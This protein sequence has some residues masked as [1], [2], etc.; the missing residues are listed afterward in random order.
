MLSIIY[1]SGASALIS[2]DRRTTALQSTPTGG[3]F[4]IL[5]WPSTIAHCSSLVLRTTLEYIEGMQWGSMGLKTSQTLQVRISVT[6]EIQDNSRVIK[7]VDPQNIYQNPIVDTL[8]VR[9]VVKIDTTFCRP[10]HH[11]D[12]VTWV[13]TRN[14]LRQNHRVRSAT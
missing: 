12:K 1:K 4:R 13:L 9:L 2:I 6:S 11:D 8:T 10:Q 3:I 14:L 5:V 7:R